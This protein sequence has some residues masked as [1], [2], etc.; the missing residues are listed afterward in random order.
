MVQTWLK[1]LKRYSNL[2]WLFNYSWRPIQDF[3]DSSRWARDR[4]RLLGF[5]KFVQA[6]FTP[7]WDLSRLFQTRSSLSQTASDSFRLLQTC[8]RPSVRI[9][10]TRSRLFL[11]YGFSTILNLIIT[12]HNP[13]RLSKTLSRLPQAFSRLSKTQ[14]NINT[15]REVLNKLKKD[16]QQS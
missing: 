15:C 5:P 9:Y 6:S 11:A 1:P 13:S 10:R 2:F 3:A 4:L 8:S 12:I 16:F 14:L 7:T